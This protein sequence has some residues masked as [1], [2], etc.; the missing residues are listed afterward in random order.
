VLTVLRSMPVL[1]FIK[2]KREVI[3]RATVSKFDV[4]GFGENIQS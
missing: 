4:G 1:L 2:D 3:L